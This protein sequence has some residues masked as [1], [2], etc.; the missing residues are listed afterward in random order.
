MQTI[1][2]I[3]SHTGGEPTRIIVAGGPDLGQGTLSERLER[4]RSEFDGVRS[5]VVNEP[6]GSDVLV[7]GLLCEPH[8]PSCSVGVLY[9]NNVG[10]LGM[11][12]HGTIGLVKTLEH[13]GRIRAGQL[14]IDTP[15]GPVEAELLEDG[16]VRVQNVTSHV[17]L[18]DVSLEV[19]ELGT[20]VGD[21]AY[22][23]N[24]FFLVKD[25]PAVTLEVAAHEHRL[26]QPPRQLTLPA[27]EHRL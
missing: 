18:R 4:F 16:R 27:H 5:A 13:M 10:Y 6:R 25:G 19:G 1:D 17:Y 15:V 11:C 24:W 26:A 3:D 12:G 2:V 7:G 23:G 20:V 9:F 22:G 14:R 8:D 21:V